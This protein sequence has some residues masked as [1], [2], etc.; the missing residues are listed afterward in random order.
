[1]EKEKK[2]VTDGSSDGPLWYFRPWVI[3]ASLVVFGPLGLILLWLR[4]ATKIYIKIVIS[5]AIIGLT[6]WMTVGAVKYYQ[7]LS[8]YYR[9]LADDMKGI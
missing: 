4:P 9:Q 2:A 8:T 1:M 6:V 7:T 3:A 5:V